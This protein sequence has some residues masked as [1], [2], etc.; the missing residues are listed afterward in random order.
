MLTSAHHSTLAYVSLGLLATTV[1]TFG[2]LMLLSARGNPPD[3]SRLCLSAHRNGDGRESE[4]PAQPQHSMMS[5]FTYL[6]ILM[7]LNLYT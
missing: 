5:I 2:Y 6:P 3:V 4:P 1:A 7:K